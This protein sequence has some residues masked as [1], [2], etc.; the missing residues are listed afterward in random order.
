MSAIERPD[1]QVCCRLV[2]DSRAS[3]GSLSGTVPVAPELVPH[4]SLARISEQRPRPGGY[5]RARCLPGSDLT[6]ACGTGVTPVGGSSHRLPVPASILTWAKITGPAEV[7]PVFLGLQPSGMAWICALTRALQDRDG[8]CI[9]E[10]ALPIRD[11]EL[12]EGL[13]DLRAHRPPV[14]PMLRI[15]G[16]CRAELADRTSLTAWLS[17]AFAVRTGAQ[18]AHDLGRRPSL[19]TC[20]L[21]QP[22]HERR[23]PL[24]GAG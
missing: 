5:G 6:V 13:L 3:R 11:S 24:P 22:P 18:T 2:V 14:V 17:A 1:R 16:D 7:V 20:H 23:P 19:L 10:S 4:R 8:V 9:I 21:G 12:V 15:E